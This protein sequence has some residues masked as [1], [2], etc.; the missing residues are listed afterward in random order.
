M[1]FL[2]TGAS[3]FV[4]SNVARQLAAEDKSAAVLLRPGG[5]RRR[6]AAILPKLTVIEGD[7]ADIRASGDA[8]AAFAPDVTL[9][10]GWQG[11]KNTDRNDPLQYDNIGGITELMRLS[12]ECGARHFIGLGSQAEY[13]PCSGAIDED[14]PA[15]PTTLYGAAKLA[16][17]ILLERLAAIQGMRFAWLRLFSSYGPGDDPSWLIPFIS[18]KLLQGETPPLTAG[19][20]IWDY[21]HVADVAAAIIAAAES[22]ASGVFNLGSGQAVALRSLIEQVRDLIDPKLS[23]GFGQIPYRPDQV[24]HLEANIA[25]LTATT[26]W[27]PKVRLAD[28]LAETVASYRV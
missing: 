20:Q 10:I 1:R 9:A 23:L 27:R 6:L 11:V 28:G 14:V 8:I 19:E 2:V 17:A 25:K 18:R 26:G 21:I 13:G 5:D 7:L 22:E 15:R 12:Y 3:G 16:S 24:M 4:G